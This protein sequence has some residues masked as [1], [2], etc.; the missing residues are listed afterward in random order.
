M[1]E[2]KATG[3]KLYSRAAEIRKK[4]DWQLGFLFIGHEANE[5]KTLKNSGVNNKF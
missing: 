1:L 5:E 4:R 3:Q 2:R